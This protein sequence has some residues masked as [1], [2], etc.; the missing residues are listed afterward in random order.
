M[1]YWI[2]WGRGCKKLV[3]LRGQNSLANSPALGQI[4]YSSLANELATVNI[5]LGFSAFLIIILPIGCL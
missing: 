2:F 4:S 5:R 1:T 3:L